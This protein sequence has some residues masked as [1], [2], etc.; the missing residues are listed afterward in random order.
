MIEMDKDTKALLKEFP[1]LLVVRTRRHLRIIDPGTGDYIIAALTGSDH[2]GLRNLR[3]ELRKLENG[4]GYS[5]W[6]GF[7]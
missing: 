6:N 7:R 2:R 3:S 4:F 5:A 1:S